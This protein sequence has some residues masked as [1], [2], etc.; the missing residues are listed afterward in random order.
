VAEAWRNLCAVGAAPLAITDNLNSQSR[1][2]GDHGQLVR[3]IDGMARPAARSTSPSSAA[4]SRSTTRRWRRHS[5]H[6]TVGAVGLL[7]DYARRADFASMREGDTLLLIG[8]S[9]G[10]LGSSLYL[11]ECLAAR[12]APA[13]DRPR[14][15][16]PR[17]R[18]RARPD[19]RGR[20]RTVHDLS[21]GGLIAAA[22]EMALASNVGLTLDATSRAHA[23]V[24]LFGEDQ[25]RY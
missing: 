6:P 8:V 20:A 15:R 12:T 16:A 14:P 4:M 19:R 10:E 5:S 9:H 7:T 21:D 1:A 13:A 23:H 11:R 17:R 25:G 22:A 2:A 18:F 3:A 24:F